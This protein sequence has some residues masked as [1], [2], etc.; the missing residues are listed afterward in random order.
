MKR[1]SLRIKKELFDQIKTVAKQEK[2]SVNKQII[3]FVRR[4][5]EKMKKSDSITV[6]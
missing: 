6:D 5:L 2:R 3:V 4:Y 1:F